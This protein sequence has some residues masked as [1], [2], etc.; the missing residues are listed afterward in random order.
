MI[1]TALLL[2]GLGTG[3]LIGREH[4]RVLFND[5]LQEI[6][7]DIRRKTGCFTVRKPREEKK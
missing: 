5:D 2:V 3:Y 1:V 6:Y 4:Q 7:R